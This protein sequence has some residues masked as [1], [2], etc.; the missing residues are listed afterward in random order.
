[1]DWTKLMVI[2]RDF[3]NN[4]SANII[5]YDYISTI[6]GGPEMELSLKLVVFMRSVHGSCRPY[7]WIILEDNGR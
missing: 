1:M 6:S 4:E 3:L 2:K 5:L 7:I